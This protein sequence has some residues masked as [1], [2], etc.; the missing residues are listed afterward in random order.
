[1]SEILYIRVNFN[2]TTQDT[3]SL[4]VPLYVMIENSHREES[5]KRAR[6]HVCDITKQTIILCLHV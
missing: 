6:R 2:N 5:T 4:C 1:M 3:I